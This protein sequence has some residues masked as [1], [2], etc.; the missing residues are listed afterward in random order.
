MKIITAHEQ[1][2]FLNCLRIQVVP[3]HHEEE[4]MESIVDFCKTHAFDNVM[5]FINAEEYNVGHMTKEEAKPW[6]ET[7]KL[8]KELLQKEGIT[9]SL[10]PWMELGHL[11]RGRMLKEGQDFTTQVDFN[12]TTCQM[13]ACPLDENWLTYFLDFYSYLIRE[14]EPEV[15][16]VEDD[17][18]LHNHPP[19]EFWG[20]FCE[21]HM[22]E[23]NK[24]LGT[25][26]TREE[27]VNRLFREKPDDEVKRVML[28]VNREC[29]TDLAKKIG[30]MIQ[31]L[32][33]GTKVGFMSSYH[34]V[35]SMEYRDWNGIHE[36]LAQT[37]TK[38]NRLH[39]P[40]YQE[41]IS[42]KQ[43]YLH[44]NY[45]PFVCRGYLPEDCHV[46]PELENATF[47]MYSKD[48]ETLR[49][50][51]ESA[52]PLEIEGMTYDIFDFTGNGAIESFG[53]GQEVASVTD[54]LTAVMESGYS[55]HNLSGITILLDEKNAYNRRIKDSFYDMYP[56]EFYFGALLQG[57][58]IS[59]RCSKEKEFENEVI[60]L[61]AGSVHNLSDTQLGNLFRD[62]HVILEGEAARLLIDRGLGNLIGA[63]SYK[64]YVENGDIH[65]YEQIEGEIFV[66][67]IPGYRASAFSRTGDY[68]C[69]TYDEKPR[70]QS[71]VYDFVGN[72]IGYGI[73]V[74]DKHLIVPY[75][76]TSFC[77]DMLHPL[78]SCIFNQYIDSLK[79]DFVRTGASN[80]Y[81]YYSKGKE[82]VLILVNPTHH[83]FSQTRFKMTGSVVQ[84]VYE[85][86]RDGTKK[87]KEFVVNED[88][89]VVLEEKFECMMTK[90]FV[91]EILYSFASNL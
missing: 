70:V 38:I 73:V 66:N 22:R 28:E 88:G 6:I 64:R 59:A 55:Y 31:D 13:V 90:T 74:I 76:V 37:G 30:K 79:K 75:A 14:I 60:V 23:F 63:S 46:L 39:L 36:G 19:L 61:A 7:M 78:R 25:S 58:G 71:K 34:Q 52:I 24:R 40:L 49:F 21:H 50:Q 45:Y 62:N 43:Y 81:A 11:D 51:L 69:I 83:T 86:E 89:F 80:I 67:G 57:N 42:L 65:S 18:R 15:V 12:G 84:S 17:F 35:H 91:L 82:S 26:Y 2:R 44:F 3:G 4:R 41:D 85:I 33:L 87:K 68:I 53:Y 56:D 77:T 32:G 47:S 27:F 29:M 9:V 8:A 54:Y 20:C 72:E 5:L 16:W 48:S 1:Q 10:N